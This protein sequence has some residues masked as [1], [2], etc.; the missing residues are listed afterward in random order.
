MRPMRLA[1][2]AGAAHAIQSSLYE[3][4]RARFHRR[5]KGMQA[6]PRA[7]RVPVYD[8]IALLF[9]RAAGRLDEML[10]RAGPQS[11]LVRSYGAKAVAPMRAMALLSANVRVL[12]IV[13]ACLAGRPAAFWWFELGPLT[14]VAMGT[15]AWHRHVEASFCGWS[16]QPAVQ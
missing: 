12:A 13:V 16:G 15:M 1:V 4:E 9:D 6:L 2:A 3:G 10:V 8:H 11:Q 7:A 14:L 5:L